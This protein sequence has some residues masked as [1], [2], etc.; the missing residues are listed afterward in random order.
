MK[1]QLF[2]K[3]PDKDFLRSF[4]LCYGITNLED[5]REFTKFDLVVIDTI[6]KI[7][8][9]VP[10][11][12]EYYIPCKHKIYLVD[13]DLNRCITILRQIIRL[14]EY[15]LVKREHVQNKKKSIYYHIRPKHKKNIS[16]ESYNAKCIINFE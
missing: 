12:I 14:Y 11:L 9:L 1:H 7:H 3:I 16:I 8:N 15:E 4:I 6:I 13:I 10:K 5:T 2:R